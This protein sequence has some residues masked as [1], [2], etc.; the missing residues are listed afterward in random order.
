MNSQ[1]KQPATP[2]TDAEEKR[3]GWPAFYFTFAR[4]LEAELQRAER[5]WDE[6]L[7]RLDAKEGELA[8]IRATLQSGLDRDKDDASTHHLA[9]IAMNALAFARRDE[10]RMD[11]LQS[12]V[13]QN[14]LFGRWVEGGSP[15]SLRLLI[16]REMKA[17]HERQHN[18]SLNP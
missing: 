1:P 18:P 9:A 10:R 4:Q 6:L 5:K 17:A 16:D 14:Y 2:R 12:A 15:N 3:L 8:K 11:W 7:E 13:V